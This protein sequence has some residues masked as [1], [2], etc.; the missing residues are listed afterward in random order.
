MTTATEKLL[1]GYNQFNK[2]PEDIIEVN[3]DLLTEVIEGVDIV[4]PTNPFMWQQ[5]CMAVG[6]YA[7]I[8]KGESVAQR[9]Y[10]KLAMSMPQLYHHMSDKDLAN[11]FATPAKSEIKLLL[12]YGQLLRSI[13][14]A[15]VNDDG[16]NEIPGLRRFHIPTGS[17]FEVNGYKLSIHYGIHI[18]V[19]FDIGNGS[20]TGISVYY[21]DTPANP[22]K[23]LTSLV[24]EYRTITYGTGNYLELT[25]P[26]E[27]F[28]ISRNYYNLDDIS[29]F[30]QL[31]GFIDNYMYARVFYLNENDGSYVEMV[32]THSLR[33]IDVITPTAILTVINGNVRVEIPDIYKRYYTMNSIRV[34]IY[35]CKGIVDY[36]IS[37]IASE[38]FKYSFNREGLTAVQKTHVTALDKIN[39][40]I[41]YSLGK[42]SGGSLAKSF[43]EVKDEVVYKVG[44]H[45][46]PI[47]RSDVIKTL[48]DLGYYT[49][50][51]IDNVTDRMY[52]ASKG[53]PETIGG[54]LIRTCMPVI[55][56]I[57][58]N[59]GDSENYTYCLKRGDYRTTI[60]PD[61]I[62]K[63]DTGV[64]YLLDNTARD[65]IETTTPLLLADILNEKPH[66]YS[67]FHY[68]LDYSLPA[69]KI[70][71]YDMLNP[72]I[73]TRDF[74]KETST[75]IQDSE[76]K[77]GTY[78]ASIEAK[79]DNTGYT[80]TLTTAVYPSSI[81]TTNGDNIECTINGISFTT[82]TEVNKKVIF[83]FDFNTEFDIDQYN[84]INF[85]SF[86]WVDISSFLDIRY[87]ITSTTTEVYEKIELEFGKLLTGLYTPGK[88][89]LSEPSYLRYTEDV[90]MVYNTT[91]FER[92]AD[93]KLIT[94]VVDNELQLTVVH[95]RGDPVL[96]S[97]G[98]PILLHKSGDYVTD[99]YGKYI[100]DTLGGELLI[101]A[102]L[103]LINE[104]YRRANDPETVAFND[105]IPETIK[106][107]LF[108]EII[109]SDNLINERTDVVFK[110]KGNLDKVRVFIGDDTETVI[111]STINYVVTVYITKVGLSNNDLVGKSINTIKNTLISATKGNVLSTYEFQD[112]IKKSLSSEIRTIDIEKFGGN[113]DIP[114]M[115]LVDIGDSFKV[116]EKLVI[117][118]AGTIAILDNIKINF[119]KLD[120]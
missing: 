21:V 77:V 8:A 18:D 42:I 76:A 13:P 17:S 28:S 52:V 11:L 26:V 37:N 15:Y 102:G 66:Y 115:S 83:T 85:D 78:S 120:I 111:D 23:P 56:N 39:D 94:V 9:M 89:L 98:L 75:A 22:M 24:V 12:N 6:T 112:K 101:N 70:R 106:G 114:I 105:S 32:T 74:V 19:K 86:G 25:I 67:P 73:I 20:A 100:V 44:K 3:M 50:N 71:A 80:L 27:Q 59:I 88:V 61:A 113:K 7:A 49:V 93:N 31:I 91:I 30:A 90:P 14:K 45:A 108:N 118:A 81:I 60:T 116:G 51:Y 103:F 119:V 2:N 110:P 82:R 104:I 69:L 40:I 97:D 68:V 58:F 54:N 55:G 43:A 72:K 96:D 57:N 95:E 10:P 48:D 62:Y 107:Y 92:D 64:L 41:V 5:E 36:D 79:E 35:T 34:D 63:F 46:I 1:N 29:D 84:K 47:L 16:V 65:V 53:L 38:N 99:N 109:P 117:T 4:D 87:A 33:V